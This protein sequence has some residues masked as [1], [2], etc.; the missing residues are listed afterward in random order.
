MRKTTINIRI[1]GVPHEI[2]TG[3]RTI[4]LRL[5]PV[6]P[7]ARGQTHTHTHTHTHQLVFI[8]PNRYQELILM[9]CHSGANG[10]MYSW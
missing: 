3:I 8:L 10:A 2:R 6:C 9:Y 1:A 5:R 7:R 4:V